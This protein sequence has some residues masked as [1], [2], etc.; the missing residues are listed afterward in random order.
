[1]AT[2][3]VLTRDEIEALLE[4]RSDRVEA[5]AAVRPV[6]LLAADRFLHDLVPLLD[7]GFGRAASAATRVLTTLLGAT[8]DVSAEATELLTGRGLYDVLAP[9]PTLLALRCVRGQA[10]GHAVLA[11]DAT[12]TYLLIERV[13]GNPKSDDGFRILERPPTRLE[14]RMLQRNLEPLVD[15]VDAA[16]EP[17][18][19]FG[20][21]VVTVESSPDLLPGLSADVTVV[22]APFSVAFGDRFAS[23]SLALPAPLLEPLRERVQPQM[24]LTSDET[25]AAVLPSVEGTVVAE[26]GATR[27][28]VADL[29]NLRVG[30]ILRLDRGP[31]DETLVYVEGRPKFSGIAVSDDGAIAVELTRRHP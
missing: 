26:L 6:D 7:V 28:T 1:M 31:G 3:P 29:T 18:A 16:L 14:R 4:L 8:V 22:H 23:F 10:H 15:A 9:A 13:F 2:E 30:Q 17:R 24:P 21:E 11:V 19:Y 25:L 27:M 12:L 20:F 5:G